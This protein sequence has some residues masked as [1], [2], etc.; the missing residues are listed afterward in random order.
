MPVCK[1]IPVGHHQA[2]RPDHTLRPT[3]PGKA[4]RT[5]PPAPTPSQG[6]QYRPSR[7][8]PPIRYDASEW[9][10]R[11][12]DVAPLS[13]SLTCVEPMELSQCPMPNPG[14]RRP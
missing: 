12:R 8:E 6:D 5:R 1:A 14:R 10:R 13:N 9:Y 11:M 4:A 2:P 3:T 7:S